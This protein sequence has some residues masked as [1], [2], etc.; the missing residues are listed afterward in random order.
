MSRLKD[1]PFHLQQKL[2]LQE[3][4]GKPKS[5]RGQMVSRSILHYGFA[6][7]TRRVASA[8]ID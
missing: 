1:G 7:L 8:K 5:A 3:H 4:S 6:D 2:P